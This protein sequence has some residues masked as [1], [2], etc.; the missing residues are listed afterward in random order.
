[1]LFVA[2]FI[3]TPQMNLIEADLKSFDK[4]MAYAWPWPATPLKWPPIRPC[5]RL[6]P[7]QGDDRHP[8]PR[9]HCE[10]MRRDRDTIP[11]QA[12]LIEPMGAET[13]IHARTAV[14]GDIR[15]VVPRSQRIK[16]GEVLHLRPDPRQTH[17]FDERRKG[18][19]RMSDSSIRHDAAPARCASKSS[20]LGSGVLALVLIF[21][22]FSF[23]P[24]RDRQRPR[25]AGRTCQQP[26]AVGPAG[27]QVRSVVTVALVVAMIFCIVLL[28]SICGGASL[29]RLLPQSAGP[30]HHRRQGAAR[31][32]AFLQADFRVGNR[33]RGSDPGAG[34]HRSQKDGEIVS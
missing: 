23:D 21:Q 15:V 2:S 6:K 14:G 9:L 4:G 27:G 30:Q 16:I 31:H 24:V 8:A 22:P 19:A 29:R 20:L 7:S 10:P 17:F 1:M 13:L 26:A 34:H 5:R 3:G 18:G 28:V 25:G 32:A 12:E 33:R 11:A